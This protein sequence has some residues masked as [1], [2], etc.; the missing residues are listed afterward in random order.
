MPAKSKAQQRFMAMCD[1]G[2]HPRGQCPDQATAREF[3]KTPRR[4]L[5][6]HVRKKK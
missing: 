3:A 2:T 1:H 6:E 5:P 4:G